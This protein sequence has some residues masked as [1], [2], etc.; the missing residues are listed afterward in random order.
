MSKGYSRPTLVELY[1]KLSKDQADPQVNYFLLEEDSKFKENNKIQIHNSIASKMSN[2]QQHFMRHSKKQENVTPKPREKITSIEIETV[3]KKIMEL[4]GKDF[5]NSYFNYFQSFQQNMTTVRG[6]M[7]HLSGEMA[8][9]KE[10]KEPNGNFI[11]K[12]I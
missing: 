4:A 11:T 6:Q 1:N 12:T 3:K 10:K 9:K 5:K 7:G 2:I 8:S